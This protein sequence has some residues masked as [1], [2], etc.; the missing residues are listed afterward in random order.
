[1][2]AGSKVA[3]LLKGTRARC[4]LL[5]NSLLKG[6]PQFPTV[7]SQS[8]SV[9]NRPFTNAESPCELAG[10]A[11]TPEAWL[12]SHLTVLRAVRTNCAT[13]PQLNM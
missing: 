13:D 10:N 1:M 9:S 8:E 12:N 2:Q 6:R 7:Y 5:S 4:S 11:D 3:Q